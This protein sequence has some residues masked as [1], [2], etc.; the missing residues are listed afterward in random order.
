[1][2]KIALSLIIF[3]AF[4]FSADCHQV[5]SDLDI[6]FECSN[7][8]VII[9]DVGDVQNT[10][11][12]LKRL[13]VV[14]E[15]SDGTKIVSNYLSSFEDAD[16]KLSYL[17]FENTFDEFGINIGGF[18]KCTDSNTFSPTSVWKKIRSKH[19]FHKLEE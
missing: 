12:Y 18:E 2:K 10:Y 8:Q 4:S 6:R 19:T 17:Y 3:A 14:T 15:N 7:R 1:M 16:C 9:L 11:K 5:K 13:R